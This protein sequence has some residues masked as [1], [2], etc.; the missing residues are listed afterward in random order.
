MN[1]LGLMSYITAL[2]R[3]FRTLAKAGLGRKYEKEKTA[4]GEMK[5]RT[6]KKLGKTK[7]D[8][9]GEERQVHITYKTRRKSWQPPPCYI[10]I[11]MIILTHPSNRPLQISKELQKYH[12]AIYNDKTDIY[13]N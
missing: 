9:K 10:T 2:I 5:D 3:L 8:I 12:P 7:R 13:Y 11:R 4:K 6:K 1:E